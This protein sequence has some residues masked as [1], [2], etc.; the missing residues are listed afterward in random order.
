MRTSHKHTHTRSKQFW[1][2]LLV[3]TLLVSAF[4]VA[5]V[6]SGR[7][8]AQADGL[9]AVRAQLQDAAY[10]RHGPVHIER[11]RHNVVHGG[12]TNDAE[13]PVDGGKQSPDGFETP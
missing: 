5:A 12:I 7:W 9:E 8:T 13:H 11:A 6:R 2:R 3:L 4:G 1:L 10:R